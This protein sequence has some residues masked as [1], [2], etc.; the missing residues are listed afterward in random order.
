MSNFGLIEENIELPH[1]TCHS[2]R[3]NFKKKFALFEA[4][5]YTSFDAY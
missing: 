1:H 5:F 2:V 4:Q 3:A